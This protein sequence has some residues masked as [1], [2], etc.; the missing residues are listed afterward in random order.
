MVA[1]LSTGGAPA[2]I[3]IAMTTVGVLNRTFS[4]VASS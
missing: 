2:Q 1:E 3:N 4:D